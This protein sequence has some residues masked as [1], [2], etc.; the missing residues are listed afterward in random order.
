[1][2][3]LK[4]DITGGFPIKLDDFRWTDNAYRS[5]FTGMI[6][7]FGI[8]DN[9][10]VILSG[11]DR[12][13]TGGTVTISEGYVSIGGE[14]CYVPEH[15]Y[16]EP[17]G[18]DVEYWDIDVSY[19]TA[20]LKMFQS[21]VSHDTYEQRIGKIIVASSTPAGYTE[22]NLAKDIFEIIRIKINTGVWNV[23][24]NQ[25]IPGVGTFTTKYKKLPTEFVH[26]SGIFYYE[27][28]GIGSIDLLIGT[29]PVGYRP[30]A[31]K[32]FMVSTGNS[33]GTVYISILTIGTN[34]EMRIKSADGNAVLNVAMCE[35]PPFE[36]V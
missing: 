14:I 12:S 30:V 27:D 8:T 23:F 24:T 35:I 20:G 29:L 9:E 16:T 5:A 4:T 34:G 22:Y 15:S 6:S 25:V 28:P 33:A 19:D 2:N 26:F 18:G 21:T 31:E 32:R 7:G 10:A 13:L 3:K 17:T 11:C 36:A 1:M